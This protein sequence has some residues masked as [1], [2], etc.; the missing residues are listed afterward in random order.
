M[1]GRKDNTTYAMRRPTWRH[2][3]PMLVVV[4][5]LLVILVT[6]VYVPLAAALVDS[7]HAHP[8]YRH[9]LALP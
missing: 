4:L 2:H 7:S 3:K 9:V 6:L 1:T 5:T 8:L